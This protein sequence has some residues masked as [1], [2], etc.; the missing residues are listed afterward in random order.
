M[1]LGA[2][3]PLLQLLKHFILQVNT[4]TSV[5]AAVSMSCFTPRSKPRPAEGA[6]ADAAGPGLSPPASGPRG[7]L[8]PAAS[9]SPRAVGA[10]HSLTATQLRALNA[11]D[12]QLSIVG[13]CVLGFTL[14][15]TGVQT[16]P[17]ATF[18]WNRVVK[19]ADGKG[20]VVHPIAGAVRLCLQ[21]FA[22]AAPSAAATSRPALVFT[23]P[24]AVQVRQQYAPEPLDL[25]LLL[26]CDVTP[27]PGVQPTTVLTAGLVADMDGLATALVRGAGGQAAAVV[28]FRLYLLALSRAA[29]RI[30]GPEPPPHTPPARARARRPR[31][32]RKR[33]WSSTAW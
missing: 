25:N 8:S 30:E 10:A 27:V 5:P 24:S 15:L 23:A 2:S 21:L 3:R 33:A 14:R 17:N 16:M 12:V 32:W 7:R 13:P 9:G 26:S 28:S 1:A 4:G 11:L 20:V 22:S 18:Q 29:R 31:A 6:A 19:T